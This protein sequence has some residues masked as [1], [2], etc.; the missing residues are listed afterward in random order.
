MNK[1]GGVIMSNSM[2]NLRAWGGR[3]PKDVTVA[4]W[5]LARESYAR[6]LDRLNGNNLNKKFRAPTWVRRLLGVYQ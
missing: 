1:S 5:W 3:K 6:L 2:L 4:R